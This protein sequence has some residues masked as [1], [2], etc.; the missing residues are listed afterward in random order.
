[1]NPLLAATEGKSPL[2]TLPNE[3]FLEV[4]PHL[5]SFKDLNAFLRT[6]RFFHT[7]FNPQLYRRSVA[8]DE[9]ACEDIVKWV[10]SEYRVASLTLLLDN[11]LSVDQKLATKYQNLDG[12]VE[13]NLD[14]LRRMCEL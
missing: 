2:Q 1:M 6:S 10:L 7:L 11:G 14:L 3:L 9:D 5:E 4:A 12:T 13:V 8:A